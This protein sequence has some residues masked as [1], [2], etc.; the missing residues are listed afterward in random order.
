MSGPIAARYAEWIVSHSRLVVVLVLVL[1]AVVAVGAV[2]GASGE[3]E[4][5]QFETD[6]E[7]TD[8]F[9]EIEAT[10]GTDDAVVAQLVVRDEAATCSPATRC[11]RGCACNRMSAK[12]R[13]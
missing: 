2:V 13:T 8:A 5:G 11:S 9:E 12:T 6:S 10:Y 7:E 4:I 3:G 1:T